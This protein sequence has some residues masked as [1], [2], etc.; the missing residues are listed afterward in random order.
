[1]AAKKKAARKPAARKTAAKPAAKPKVKPRHQ[2][3]NLRIRS[4]GAGLTVNDIQKS[5]EWYKTLG[6]IPGDK[7][8]QGGK[9]MGIEMKC[10]SV[11]FW[12]N[13]DDWAKG[14]GRVKG[15]GVR[16]YCNTAQDVR[17]IAAG[18]Q[19]RGGMLDHEPET[20]S[21]GGTDFGMTDPDGFK[22]TIQS[23]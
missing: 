5:I 9:L 10:G 16:L 13:Q 21:W 3:E 14:T 7:W 4:I 11:G 12:L 8:E 19:Q 15:V 2:P 6:F 22:I 1:M 23:M 20:R 18:I 17:K